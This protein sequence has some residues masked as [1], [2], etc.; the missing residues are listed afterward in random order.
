MRWLVAI[1]C[2]QRVAVSCAQMSDEDRQC[3]ANLVAMSASMNSVCCA[4]ASNCADGSPVEC[5]DACA[6]VYL[7][8]HSQ[9]TTISVNNTAV[10]GKAPAESSLCYRPYSWVPHDA[11]YTSWLRFLLWR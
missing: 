8:F 3:E 9:V 11:L 10:G 5:S 6:R 7:P 4:P 1:A 2:A